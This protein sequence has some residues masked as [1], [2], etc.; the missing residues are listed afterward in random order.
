MIYGFFNRTAGGQ[1]L[2]CL[3]REFDKHLIINWQI[4][5]VAVDWQS[6]A[7]C[8]FRIFILLFVANLEKTNRKRI[9]FPLSKSMSNCGEYVLLKF[10]VYS[11]YY[12]YRT[13]TYWIWAQD[14]YRGLRWMGQAVNQTTQST[15]HPMIPTDQF[16]QS[17]LMDAS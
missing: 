2:F 1:V 11:L 6:R 5:A 14:L 8:L 12:F 17:V 16:D 15:S 7:I 4:F 13:V 9:F 3:L 10:I